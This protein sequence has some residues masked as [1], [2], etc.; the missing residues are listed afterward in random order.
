MP[1]LIRYWA[2]LE[3]RFGDPPYLPYNLTFQP[4]RLNLTHTL[5]LLVI[6]FVE[7]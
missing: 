6:S 7:T 5:V 4:H 1:V 3:K 2:G